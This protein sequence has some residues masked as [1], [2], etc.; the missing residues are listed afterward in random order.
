MFDGV[1]LAHPQGQAL[2]QRAQILASALD[3]IRSDGQ[4]TF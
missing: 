2:K 1:D 4:G 3:D